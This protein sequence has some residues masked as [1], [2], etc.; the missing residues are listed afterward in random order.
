MSTSNAQLDS[1]TDH[2]TALLSSFR[3]IR[4]KYSEV[5]LPVSNPSANPILRRLTGADGG[6]DISQLGTYDA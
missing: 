4:D 5:Q 3:V 6:S 1:N 2:P